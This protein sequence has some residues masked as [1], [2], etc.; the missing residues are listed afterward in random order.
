MNAN[1]MAIGEF[2]TRVVGGPD[3]PLIWF[4]LSKL[5]PELCA[6]LPC[7][8]IPLSWV[9]FHPFLQYAIYYQ[10][11]KVLFLADLPVLRLQ[12]HHI[13]RLTC[14]C[15]QPMQVVWIPHIGKQSISESTQSFQLYPAQSV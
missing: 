5:L 13:C 10:R 8:F 11:S 15:R 6:T 7:H 2:G 14:I 3:F 4:G 9:D 12:D 1:V